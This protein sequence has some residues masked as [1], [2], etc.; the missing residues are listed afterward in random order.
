MVTMCDGQS[1]A[2]VLSAQFFVTKPEWYGVL[3][4]ESAP[5][6][7]PGPF[8]GGPAQKKDLNFCTW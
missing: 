4:H 2:V 6:N 8:C 5:E 1:E 7:P 3:Y